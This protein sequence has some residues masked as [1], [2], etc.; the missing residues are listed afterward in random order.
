MPRAC[1]GVRLTAASPGGRLARLLP[2]AVHAAVVAWLFGGALSGAGVFYF[3]DIALYY[4]PNYV[5]LERELAR[6]VWPLWNPWSDAGAPFLVAYPVDL[7]LVGVLGARGALAV[8]PP[9]H[10]LSAMWGSGVLAGR[11][12][13]GAWGR[14]AA[15]WLFGA[16]GYL[17]STLNLFEL[18]HGAALAAWVVA[19]AQA[20]ARAPSARRAAVLA[21]VAALQGTSLAA[22]MVLATGI[23]VAVLARPVTRR[24][25]GWALAA[26]LLALLLAAPA[27]LGARALVAGTQRAAGFDSTVS[28][29]WSL[30]PVAVADVV[31]PRFFGDVHAFSDLGFWGQPFFTGGY[32]Y[33]L[34]LYAGLPSLLL[35]SASGLRPRR[36]WAL[37]GL[38]LLLS[39]GVH[40]PLAPAM[41]ALMHSLRTPVKLFVLVALPLSLLGGLGLDAVTSGRSRGPAWALVPA[42]LLVLMAFVVARWPEW[43][44]T[45]MSRFV[46]G[47]VQG[48]AGPV[49]ALQWPPAFFT[50]GLLSLGVTLAL[51]GGMRTAP[52]AGLLAGCDLLIANASINALAPSR[53]YDL[54]PEV[55]GLLSAAH[56]EDRARCFAYGAEATPGLIWS[57]DVR[58]RNRDV[59]LFAA[60]RQSLLPRTSVLD[61]LE[62]A[63]DEDRVGWS[64]RGSTLPPSERRPDRFRN[65]VP[66][67]RLANVRWVLSFRELPGDE[68]SAVGVARVREVAE[69]LRLYELRDALPRAFWVGRAEVAAGQDEALARSLEA[70]FDPRRAV[71]LE[72]PSPGRPPTPGAGRVE[73][74]AMDAHTVRVRVSSPPGW[75]VVLDGHHPGWRSDAGDA[76]LRAYGRYRAV[77]TP[78]GNRSFTLRYAPDWRLGALS[79][80]G[81]GAVVLLGLL[82]SGRPGPSGA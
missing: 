64:P 52:W 58:R 81:V 26:A 8:G 2:F 53:F 51:L 34:S 27:L 41:P 30:H 47:V 71:V 5:F 72:S 9:L 56:A 67:L 40:G 45:L 68:A 24:F 50:S 3:R 31:L 32:P 33:L 63:F 59:A 35:A 79:A 80:S 49:V 20:L 14:C 28:L 16:S 10:V 1:A 74:E 18:S 61:G 17:L 82:L 78:G 19:A 22:E 69:P 44:V 15:G 38:G 7:L 77:P 39:L 25:A 57:P 46:P 62:A 48:L 60:E 36:L 73:Y 66:L 55:R 29:A 12:G 70:G 76:V 43:A 42:S 75:V 37:L 54:Q 11:L 6:G 65:H 4:Y 21:G 23:M 13:A